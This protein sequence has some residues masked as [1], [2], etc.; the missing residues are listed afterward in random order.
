MNPQDPQQARADEQGMPKKT[1]LALAILAGALVI[2]AIVGMILT[3]RVSN[4]T[5]D[6]SAKFSSS[7]QKLEGG[8]LTVEFKT[9]KD[10]PGGVGLQNWLESVPGHER[11]TGVHAEGIAIYQIDNRGDWDLAA[12]DG[13]TV[14][15]VPAAELKSVTLTREGLRINVNGAALT[16]E[17]QELARDILEEK[18]PD[19]LRQDEEARRATRLPEL[20][21]R[22]KSFALETLH[23]VPAE[24]LDIAFPGENSSADPEDA[25]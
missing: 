1:K 9:S 8:G 3:Y 5:T 22:V 16:A 20:K 17:D 25:E 10:L 19:L 11:V 4:L 23:D 15:T 6:S 13:R 7:L 24:T 21:A 18:V 2:L 12:H 14:L